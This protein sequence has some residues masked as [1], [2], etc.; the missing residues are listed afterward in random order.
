[1]HNHMTRDIKPPGQCPECDKGHAFIER[2]LAT[3]PPITEERRRRIV[4]MLT[5][6]DDE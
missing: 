1:M 3:A 2:T 6:E 5:I 4:R